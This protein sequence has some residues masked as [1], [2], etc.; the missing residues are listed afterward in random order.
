MKGSYGKLVKRFPYW[1]VTKKVNPGMGNSH[2]LRV[3]K[4]DKSSEED[5]NENVPSRLFML[6]STKDPGVKIRVTRNEASPGK[7][8]YYGRV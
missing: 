4:E 6:S 2:V 5:A 3:R 1:R 8:I 7:S